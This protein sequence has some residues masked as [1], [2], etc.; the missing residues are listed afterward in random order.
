MNPSAHPESPVV[1]V[2]TPA[3]NAEQTLR[4]TVA[5]VVAQE[6]KDWEHI[7]VDDASHDQT[8]RLMQ[9]LAADD[10]RLRIFRCDTNRG[11]AAARNVALQHARGEFIALLDAD[12]LLEPRY[13]TTMISV[14]R[15]AA[16][17]GRAIGVVGCDA[18]KIGPSGGLLSGTYRNTIRTPRRISTLTLL[19]RNVVFVS[20]LVPR[21]VANAAGGFSES[22]RGS[23][24]HDLWIKIAEMGFEILVID[25]P[26]VRY[27]VSEGSLSASTAQMHQ[28][29]QITYELALQRGLLSA[30]ERAL[31]YRRLYG[32]RRLS[33]V[34]DEVVAWRR[35]LGRAKAGL[36]NPALAWRA[37]R[38]RWI[39]SR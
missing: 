18:F 10:K 16:R 14:Y 20:A 5:S 33:E 23:E 19:D 25:S 8:W 6:E 21:S 36:A 1:S 31:A 17:D 12:D 7:V 13:L 39:Q 2:I 11:P 29:S 3:F 34:D 15:R 32:F 22:A 24:D 27:R 38:A 30:R 35:A 26:L 9:G 28:T 37:V 4:D